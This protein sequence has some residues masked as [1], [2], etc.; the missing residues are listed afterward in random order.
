MIGKPAP[1]T[2]GDGV[3]K[4]FKESCNLFLSNQLATISSNKGYVWYQSLLNTSN[5]VKKKWIVQSWVEDKQ[6][7]NCKRGFNNELGFLRFFKY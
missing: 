6:K 4:C 1:R 7:L 3:L 5:Y 2:F